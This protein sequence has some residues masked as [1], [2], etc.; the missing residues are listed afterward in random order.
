MAKGCEPA[1][2]TYT[3]VTIPAWSLLPPR[4]LPA[5]TMCPPP[6]ATGWRGAAF[7]YRPSRGDFV[8]VTV[9]RPVPYLTSLWW[10]AGM[11]AERVSAVSAVV[12]LVQQPFYFIEQRSVA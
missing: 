5:P 4:L 3:Q 6:Q 8:C 7:M 2:G 9:A 10:T 1:V 11:S 12:Y